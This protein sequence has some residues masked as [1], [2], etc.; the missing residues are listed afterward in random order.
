[1]NNNQRRP[2][3]RSICSNN[4]GSFINVRTLEYSCVLP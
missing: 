2:E 1:L 4:G 3:A